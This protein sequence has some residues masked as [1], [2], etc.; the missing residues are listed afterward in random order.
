[1]PLKLTITSYQRLS[2]GQETTRILDRGSISIGRSA[3]CDWILQ[4]PEKI[5][6]NKHCTVHHQDGGYFLTD[7]STNGVYLNDSEQRIGRGE[8]VRLQDGDRFILGEYEIAVALT[9]T[10]AE[11]DETEQEG[12]IT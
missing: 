10:A 4:D 12:P 7:I 5:L 11:L 2:P 1:M 9:P 8:M 3:Q 6:S